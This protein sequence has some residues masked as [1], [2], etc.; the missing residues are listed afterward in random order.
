MSACSSG[1]DSPRTGNPGSAG[2]AAGSSGQGSAGQGAAGQGSAGQGAAGQGAAGQG[3]AGQ[4]AAGQGAAGQGSAGQGAAGQGAAGQG[5]AG[6][7]AAGQGAAGQGAAGQGAGGSGMP[8]KS[9]GCNM[10]PGTADSP[11]AWTKKEIMVTGVDQPFI[12][13][14]PVDAGKTYSWTKRNYY[15]RLPKGYQPTNVYPMTMAGT[16]CQGGETIGSGGEYTLPPDPTGKSP[17]TGQADAIQISLSY[18]NSMAAETCDGAF[19]DDYVNSP[20][21]AYLSAVIDDVAS[22]YCIDKNKVFLNG[23]SSGAFETITGGC[24]NADKIRGIG[25][26]IGGG[27]RNHHYP[28]VN[29][30][31]AAMFVVGLLDQGNPIGPLAMQLNDST[32]SQ[33]ARDE[34]LKRNG[35]VDA[36]TTIVDTCAYD[37]MAADP[38]DTKPPNHPLPCVAGIASGDTYGSAPHAMWNP[39]YPKCQMYT[40]CPAKYPVVWCPLLVNHGNGPNPMGGDM[41]TT[42]ESYRLQGI[43]DFYMSLPTP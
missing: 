9:T 30:P 34:I 18:V 16:G 27:L 42:L 39:K 20:E 41:G 19:A 10:P 38:G 1:G 36:N 28:C 33:A 8:V 23:Y 24:G 25:V 37:Y 11:T 13:K 6:Q 4:G 32:G 29:H 40:G 14:Y 7:G 17:G 15:L 21:P 5:A 35:C 43:W 26:Q 22:K 12:D 2:S 31:V 3:S